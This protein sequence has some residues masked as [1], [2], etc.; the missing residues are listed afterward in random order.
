MANRAVSGQEILFLTDLKYL[1]AQS[2]ANDFYPSHA[3]GQFESARPRAARIEIQDAVFHF[4][5]RLM[6]V[7]AD[8][9]RKAGS[10]GIEVERVDIMDDVDVKSAQLDN[11]RFLEASRPCLRVHIAANRRYGRHPFQRRDN[12]RRADI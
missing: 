5:F 7:P 4:L 2:A 1:S 12:L 10:L 8:H 3:D 11:F 6:R 9:C